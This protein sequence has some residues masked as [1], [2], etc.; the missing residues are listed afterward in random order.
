[1]SASQKYLKTT[2]N[3]GRQPESDYLLTDP[4]VSRQH[5][6]LSVQGD[7]RYLLVDCQSTQGTRLIDRSGKSRPVIR[8]WVKPEDR[9]Q[10]GRVTVQVKEILAKAQGRPSPAQPDAGGPKTRCVCGAVKIQGGRC[11]V[12]G[13]A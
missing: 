13:Q 2:I 3:I 4:S 7:G 10:F 11:H 5:A 8:E 12:C 1:M 9:V 6:E